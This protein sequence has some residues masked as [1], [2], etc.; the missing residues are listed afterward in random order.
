MHPYATHWHARQARPASICCPTEE[1]SIDFRRIIADLQR[2][3]Y[4]GTIC[5]EFTPGR[6]MG[7]GPVD[8]VSETTALA[9][10]LRE[11]LAKA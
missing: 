5:L 11:Y 8:C 9:G 10:Q 7:G 1:G 4:E 3:G 2:A 6:W